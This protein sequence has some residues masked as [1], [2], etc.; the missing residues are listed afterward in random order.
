MT[1]EIVTGSSAYVVVAVVYTFPQK[2][3]AMR[4]PAQMTFAMKKGAEGWKIAGW[5]WTG[6]EPVA[7]K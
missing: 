3:V 4:E 1:R 6:P 2:G 7:A 5:T